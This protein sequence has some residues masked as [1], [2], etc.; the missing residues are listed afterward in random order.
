MSGN[1]F[2]FIGNRMF[3]DYSRE[4]IALATEGVSPT[5][6]DR[7]VKATGMAMGPFATFDLS[8][9]DVF[10]HIQKERPDSLGGKSSVV[11]TMYEQKRWG[12]KTGA[13]FH[14]Y[15]KGNREPQRAP[16]I[17][18]LFAD[19]AKR[20]GI[21]PREVSDE[22]I[23]QRLFLAL[24]NVGADLLEKGI[25]LR[26]GDEDIVFIYGYGFPPH[27]GGP[28][29]YADALGVAKA[30]EIMEGFRAQFGD[31][32]TPAPLLVEIAQAAAVPSRSI[33]RSWLMPEAAIVSAARLPI[34]K[35]FRGAFNQTHG[36]TMAGHVI[37]HAIERAGVDPAEVEDVVIGT[38]LPEGATGHNIGRV[39]ALRAGLPIA[40][41][42]HHHQPLLRVGPAGDLDRG[43]PRHGRRREGHRR[44]R[45]RV[46]LAGAERA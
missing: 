5:R 19:E 34:G 25:A 17:E 42:R 44:R 45:R 39:A 43:R 21:A 31:Q 6:I 12:Q 22:E 10:Y 30:V 35:A 33:R 26:P 2:G 8:G 1:A 9:V 15:V 4:A 38:G 41:A 40:R 14:N 29:W 27:L 37:E 3:F 24:A 13:G 7:V 28:M 36:A 16:E 20:L 23:V 32:W 18:A 11:D 46:D